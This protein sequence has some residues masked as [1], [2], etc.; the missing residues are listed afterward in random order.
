MST[1]PPVLANQANAK[2]STRPATPRAKPGRLGIQSLGIERARAITERPL[3]PNPDQLPRIQT[4]QQM[5]EA[6]FQRAQIAKRSQPSQSHRLISQNKPNPLQCH[7][8]VSQNEA[9]PPGAPSR[10][11]KTKPIRTN[12]KQ[13]QSRSSERQECAGP[14]SRGL[15]AVPYGFTSRKSSWGW[16]WSR[17]R[18]RLVDAAAARWG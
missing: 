6:V 10:F 5:R 17:L 2:L 7:R 4:D 12:A 9:N 3:Q 11:C 16:G 8:P 15:E 18:N 14:L 13:T 1:A